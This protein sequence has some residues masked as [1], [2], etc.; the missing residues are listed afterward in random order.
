MQIECGYVCAR[1]RAWRLQAFLVKSRSAVH[2][3]K[4]DLVQS[5]VHAY[6]LYMWFSCLM[7]HAA[8]KPCLCSS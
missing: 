3:V 8:S 6:S 7:R 2:G 4:K 1:G 5:A